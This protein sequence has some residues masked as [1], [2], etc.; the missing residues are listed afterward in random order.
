MGLWLF[1]QIKAV[2][3]VQVF[4]HFFLFYFIF[5]IDSPIGL[6]HYNYTSR[7]N[8]VSVCGKNATPISESKE[9]ILL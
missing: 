6:C 4:L 5:S 7:D 2:P 3:V 8:I 9:R 1:T